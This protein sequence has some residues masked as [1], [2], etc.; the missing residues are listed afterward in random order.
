MLVTLSG[1]VTAE[2]SLQPEKALSPILSM[3]HPLSKVISVTLLLENSLD[4]RLETR[5]PTVSLN[6]EIPENA[7]PD[8]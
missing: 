5:A 8:A 3:A 2:S 7:L 4:G 6:S 1:R